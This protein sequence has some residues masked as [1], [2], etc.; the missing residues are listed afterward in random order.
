MADWRDKK[1]KRTCETCGARSMGKQCRACF[2]TKPPAPTCP[3]CGT[4]VS[5]TGRRCMRCNWARRRT[6]EGS[7]TKG[8]YRLVYRPGHPLAR[9]HNGMVLEHRLAAWDAG[10]L[11][12]PSDH[13]HHINGNKLDNRLENL[14]VLPASEHHRHHIHQ[15]GH[16]VNQF[17]VWPLKETTP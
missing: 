17:G 16:I 10:L 8:G 1:L 2:W 9:A 6:T 5:E 3:D 15:A 13:V 12:D 7:V 4:T 11:I 14:E